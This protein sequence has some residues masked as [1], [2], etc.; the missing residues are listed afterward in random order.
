MPL[1]RNK[2]E[3]IHWR[4]TSDLIE[5]SLR[6]VLLLASG[7][8]R[9][10]AQL[11]EAMEYT[12][13][14]GGKRLRAQ[15][16]IEA[17]G[18]VCDLHKSTFALE[19][20]LPA[21]CAIELIHAYSLVHD[22]LPSMDDSDIRR[23]QPSC[24]KKFGE[25]QAI[26]AGDGLLNLAYEV[27]LQNANND[28]ALQ[29]AK[30]LSQAAGRIGMVGGQYQDICWSNAS[31]LHIDAE[32]LLTMQARKT[33]AL[34]RAAVECGALLA[35]ATD[36]QQEQ[37]RQY[38]ENFGKAFQLRDDVLDVECDPALTGKESTD[39]ANDKLTAPAVLGLEKTKQLAQRA[40][41]DALANLAG[42][43]AAGNTL[44]QLAEFAVTRN[45]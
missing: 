29:A 18:A 23:G 19:D 9:E 5:E 43:G 39:D 24:H 35:N 31:D 38:G 45:T 11:T 27:L 28:A 15:L 25:A 1:M 2:L 3:G 6:K 44:R 30:V 12:V 37:L 26:L 21:A 7:N 14:G 36:E 42:W 16:V 17:A 34:I 32:Q 10:L 40:S 13:L 22:D 41:D 8:S 33:G 4:V 20:Y